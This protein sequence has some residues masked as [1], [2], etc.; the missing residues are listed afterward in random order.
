M[1]VEADKEFTKAG[2]HMT[3]LKGLIDG[4]VKDVTGILS[5]LS[6]LVKSI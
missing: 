1:I 2:E 6:E 5:E 3:K 4:I